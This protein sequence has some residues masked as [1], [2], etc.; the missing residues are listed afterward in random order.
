VDQWIMKHHVFIVERFFKNDDSDV[1]TQWMF[2]KHFNIAHH[3][4]VPC[5]NTIQ[6]WVENFRM[7]GSAL[8]KTRQCAYSVIATEHWGCEAVIHNE[9]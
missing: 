3:G 5:H 7:S 9:S 2:H 1:K 8:K 6:L 4:K